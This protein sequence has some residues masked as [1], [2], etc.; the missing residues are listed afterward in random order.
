MVRAMDLTGRFWPSAYEGIVEVDRLVTAEDRLFRDLVLGIDQL[1]DN[2]FVKTCDVA[3]LVKWEAMLGIIAAPSVET[4]DFRRERI[5]N[6]LTMLPPFTMRFFRHRLDQLLGTGAWT[7]QMSYAT[8]SL[9]ILAP[10]SNTAWAHEIGVTILQYLPANLIIIQAPVFIEDFKVTNT[11]GLDFQEN[12]Y[13]LDG[14]W[15]LGQNPFATITEGSVTNMA[16]QT[17]LGGMLD[18]SAAQLAHHIAG[19][20]EAV[21]NGTVTIPAPDIEVSSH[22]AS[23][24]IRFSILASLGLETITSIDLH[25]NGTASTQLIHQDNLSVDAHFD[26]LVAQEIRY[27]AG[28]ATS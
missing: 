24:F 19:Q 11:L 3:T 15:K 10:A 17:V 4:V 28:E 21:V 2:Q 1:W 5:V 20:V 12:H 9:T 26:T 16:D 27:I 22:G 23:I 18:L 25:L 14:R 8:R 6:R 7:L 13:I